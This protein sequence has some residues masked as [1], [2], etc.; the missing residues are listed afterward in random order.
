MIDFATITPGTTVEGTVPGRN[1][2]GSPITRTIRVT[3]DRTPWTATGGR[4]VI[5]ATAKGVDAVI[6]ETL[7]IVAI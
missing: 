6:A 2:D 3:V 7:R 5:L 4:N 1:A